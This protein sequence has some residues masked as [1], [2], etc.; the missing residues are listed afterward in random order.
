MNRKSLLKVL[1]L[2]PLYCLSNLALAETQIIKASTIITM[3]EK[4]PRAEAVAFDTVTKKI[5]AVG[6]LSDV[7]AKAPQAKVTDLGTTV[8][9]PGF[10]EPHGHPILAGLTTQ[11]PSYWIAPYVGYKTWTK[12]TC[13][14]S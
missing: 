4:N 5:T 7:K 14:P 2:I 1:P 12:N 9:M 3:D 10:V 13:I 6:S 11:A 8:L